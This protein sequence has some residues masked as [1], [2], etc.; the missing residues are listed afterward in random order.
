LPYDDTIPTS[1][2][3]TQVLSQAITPASSSSKIR[4]TAVIT[5]GGANNAAVI[6]AVFRGGTCIDV[7]TAQQGNATNGQALAVS[8]VLDSP[9]TGSSVTYSVRAGFA[10]TAT[11]ASASGNLNGGFSSRLFGG[12]SACTLTLAEILP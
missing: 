2:E 4:V 10:S 6:L 1:S 5:G 3:G 7:K 11:G 8:D 12:A 9:A